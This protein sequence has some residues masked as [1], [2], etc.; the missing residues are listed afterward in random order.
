MY[1]DLVGKPEEKEQ[2]EDIGVQRRIILKCNLKK[3]V[4]RVRT[5]SIWLRIEICD[6]LL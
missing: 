4:R 5:G 6:R 3:W 1:T 2:S